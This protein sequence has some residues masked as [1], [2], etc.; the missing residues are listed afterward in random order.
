VTFLGLVNVQAKDKWEG[1]LCVRP[2]G[3]A[4]R[5]C[6]PLTRLFVTKLEAKLIP[7]GMSFWQA[8]SVVLRSLSRS[9]IPYS[10]I[11]NLF[12]IGFL[13][14]PIAIQFSLV[15]SLGELDSSEGGLRCTNCLGTK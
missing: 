7:A 10:V 5:L 15:Y 13:T 11:Q 4:V 6:S 14:G 8:P 3:R 1:T 12:S 2:E 9:L